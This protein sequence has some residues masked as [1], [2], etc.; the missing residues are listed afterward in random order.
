MQQH[1]PR[2]WAQ[3]MGLEK[4]V[5]LDALV[6]ALGVMAAGGVEERVRLAFWALDR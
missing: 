5:R 3:G 1:A 2:A 6:C 4:A